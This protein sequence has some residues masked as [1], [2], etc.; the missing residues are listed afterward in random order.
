M[1]RILKFVLPIDARP[2]RIPMWKQDKVIHVAEQHGAVTLWAEVTVS[3][4]AAEG[5]RGPN[6]GDLLPSRLF[7][8]LAT[9]DEIHFTRYAHVGTAVCAGG[10]LVWHVYEEQ[11]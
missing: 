2:Y 5:G 7:V 9:G 11:P 3:G 4:Y 10:S 6:V 8:V 1:K